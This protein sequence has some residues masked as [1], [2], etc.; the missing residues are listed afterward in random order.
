MVHFS[1]GVGVGVDADLAAELF[2]EAKVEVA[3]VGTRG[4]GVVLYGHAEFRAALKHGGE[5]VGISLAA[6]KDA[7]GGVAEDAQVGVLDSAQQTG[8]HLSRG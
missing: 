3:E 6:Q 8:S 2:G 7:S 4:C 1:G 5:V